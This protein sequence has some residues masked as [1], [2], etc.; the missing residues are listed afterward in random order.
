MA[1]YVSITSDKKKWKAF[2][3]CLFFGFIGVHYFYVGRIGRGLIA[4]LTVNFFG[5]GW[6][7]DLFTILLG[8]F[9]DN[10]GQY[11]RQ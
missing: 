4:I 5:I 9:K 3:L 8:K 6:V 7:I 11:L 1:N 10:A 2:F